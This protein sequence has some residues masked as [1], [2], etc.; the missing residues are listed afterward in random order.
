[1]RQKKLKK[2]FIA[3]AVT[4]VAASGVV[5]PSPTDAANQSFPDVKSSDYFH[6]AVMEL[7]GRGVINGFEDGKFRP[8][9]NVTR[10][11]AAVII[12]GA[13]GL[14]TQNTTNPGFKDVPTTHPYYG[15]ISALANAG[16]IN[17]FADGTFGAEKPITRN[18]MAIIIAK[19]F[20]LEAPTN[21]TLPFTDIYPD[22]KNQIAALYVNG[23]TAGTSNTTFGGTDNVTRGQLAQFVVK[24]E[25]VT[26]SGTVENSTTFTIESVSN[27]TIQTSQGELKIDPSLKTILN[28]SNA[29][30]LEK[31]E[32]KAVVSDGVVKSIA[33][34]TLNSNGSA[35]TPV[36]FDGGKATISGDVKVNA[37]NVAFNNVTVNG[38]LTLT[39]KVAEKFDANG[40]VTNGELVIE[41]APTSPV[42][43]LNGFV[44]AETTGPDVNFSA[45]TIKSI[46]AERDNVKISSDKKLP[47]LK[48]SAKV[49]SIEVNTDVE[50]VTV[51]VTVKIEIKGTG[52]I[53]QFTL[54]QAEELALE[55]AGQIK[56]L[57]VDKN[58][59]AVEIG[60]NV[61]ID[62]LIVP[63]GSNVTTIVKNFNSV[64]G[65]IKSIKDNTG[66]V[67]NPGNNSGGGSGGSSGGGG[68]TPKENFKLSIMHTNDTHG[69]VEMAP[70]RATAVKEVR[71]EN[72]NA[73]L[74]DAGDVFSGTLYFNE[75]QGEADLKLMNY[76][77]YDVMTF[78]NHE[79]D[80]G[81]SAEGHQALV[82]FIEAAKFSFVSSNI[83]FTKD[84]KFTGLFNDL[85]S[86]DPENGKIYSGI[87][88]EIDG[89]K[90]GIFG[91]TTA[92]TENIS[93][94]GSITF[95]DYIEEA[96]KAV[97]AF[98]NM[99]VDKIIAVTHIGFD[100][101]ANVDN[102]QVLAQSVE[103]IDVIVGGHSHTNLG[104]PVVIDE[105][106]A[107]EEKEP[108]VIVQA[109]QYSDYLGTL[110]VTFDKNGEVVEFDGELLTLS[111][112]EEDAGALEILAPYK[113]H[114]DAVQNE[115]I[116]ATA[117]SE[118]E[119]PRT[120]GDNTKPSVRKNETA[121]GNLITDG[122]V[123]KA[124]NYT[125][126][127]VIMAVQNGGGI[128]SAINAGPITVGEVITVLPFGNTL[129][130]MDI[131][132]AELKEAFEHSVSQYPA[133]SGGFL[134]VSTGVKVEFD[135]TKPAGERIISISY[136]NESGQ[137]V[138]IVDSETYTIATNAFTAK[139]GDGFTMFEKAYTE[140][141]VIDLGLSD[142]ENFKEHLESIGT[143]VPTVEG[144]IVDVADAS[145]NLDLAVTKAEEAVKFFERPDYYWSAD[146]E[147]Q[148]KLDAARSAV[149]AVLAIDPEY[150]TSAWNEILDHAK[151]I[152][153]KTVKLEALAEEVNV[154]MRDLDYDDPFG[155]YILTEEDLAKATAEYEEAI[156]KYNDAVAQ[157]ALLYMFDTEAKNRLDYQKR[158]IDQYPIHVENIA[159]AVAAVEGANYTDLAIVE[160][161]EEAKI[162]AVKKAAD[163]AIEETNLYFGDVDTEVSYNA[164]DSNFD[165]KVFNDWGL[166]ETVAISA[167]FKVEEDPE[168]PEQEPITGF[169]N[170]NP[171]NL[172][173][174]QIA[175]YDS[176]SG[177]GGTEILAYDKERELAF[178]TNGA[179]KGFDI[180]SFSDL[181]SGEFKNVSASQDT[182]LL[183]SFD[184]EGVS[185]IT[186][187]ASHPTENLIAISAVSANKTDNGYIVFAT[188]DGE[189][190]NHVEVGAL[191]DMVTFTP[192]GTKAIVANE[193]EPAEDYSVD[194]E[195]SISIININID[196]TSPDTTTLNFTTGDVIT[197]TF[198]GNVNYDDKVRM[199]SHVST[200][201]SV[202]VQLEPEYVTV[203]ADS[204]TAYVSLQENN[205]I[206][207]ID[208]QTN[209]ILSVKGLGVKDYSIAGNEVDAMN[210]K[211]IQLEKQPILSFYMPDAID[212]IMKDGKTYIVTPNEGD[213]RDWDAYSEEIE[214]SDIIENIDLRAEHYEGY[215]QEE[216]DAYVEAGGLEALADGKL[217]LTKEQGK[218]EET[219]KYEALYGFGG[220]SFSIFD[221]ETMELIFDSGSDF[222]KFM[223]EETP[224]YFNTT[225][226]ETKVDNRSDDKG[227]EPET[228]I[229]GE[230]DGK[231][232]S[233]IAL[234]RFGGIAVYDLSDLD[235]PKFV[236]VISSRNFE[237][238]GDLEEDVSPTEVAELAG[239]VSPEGL[240]FI[241]ANES[242]TGK[243]LLV[244]THE[245]SG[246]VAVYELGEGIAIPEEPEEA[247]EVPANEFSG[248]PENPKEYKGSV[249][250]DVS[251]IT[252]LENAV[253]KGDLILSGSLKEDLKF[254]NVTVE[255]NADLSNL[256]GNNFTFEGLVV[257]GD[258]IL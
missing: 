138:E 142:W 191:P 196:Q 160:E 34:L 205:A 134:H 84:S 174:S 98:G 135:S 54:Q 37:D 217:K 140:G 64:K 232:Y 175:R 52:S 68:S 247:V 5:A 67:I 101:N 94:P 139:G 149:N 244:A 250:V 27:A 17:G 248:T 181:K 116:N 63:T 66:S 69:H 240:V 257:I 43:S 33:S 195:G 211:K 22:Y 133:E 184:I 59:T 46:L 154:L 78:G 6:D 56:E 152:I 75:F 143:I 12:A 31:A 73:L 110:D 86:S 161:T 169:Y 126:K 14:D 153:D 128:R 92:E 29:A 227:P 1:M 16:Y 230:I 65:K 71:A 148:N 163:A 39:S 173:A 180:L 238:E 50:K 40:L 127:E 228:A 216:L 202:Y 104:E 159:I 136:T 144:R 60:V 151:E 35:K 178:V 113:E 156:T 36:V 7:A 13:L 246:T 210:D 155:E 213:V 120:G 192:D 199:N 15:A 8:Y 249:K 99:G 157:G 223:A 42:A 89:E 91:L 150:D 203:T 165:V 90:V 171:E 103:G 47:E 20:K 76:M 105:N 125:D 77:G 147:R 30:A 80:L 177:L 26:E 214:V 226:N 168:L 49:S 187:I 222:E 229:V 137:L 131:T 193:G 204:K 102:D 9:N 107:G 72:P 123:N 162:E 132:G 87:V 96:E 179:K 221:A 182:I 25:K 208:L 167:T 79:F 122:M 241:P 146:K 185:D 115:V 100:D 243:A 57:I 3:S 111:E 32:V 119:S 118:L 176:N 225:N 70:K 220:R 28:S 201:D 82:D 19:A 106:I 109:Y 53:D 23:V 233:F 164:D 254:T 117:A 18:H 41:E 218:N 24:A 188:K 170:S 58:D 141:R 212:V 124:K 207:K 215:T 256:E 83:D 234:E 190:I 166:E 235:N 237:A 44:A 121:L 197:L 21:S 85:V 97:K 108:T 48:I 95:E 200:G 242:P 252:N 239:D 112:Y 236:T 251:D 51:N 55:V 93:S 209:Q 255:G 145:N 38:K 61:E 219:G 245:V 258:T 198:D 2:L 114:V 172:E 81:S 186:S 231:P 74:L 253:I 88:K 11:Q 189:Y 130:L 183:E 158:K 224:Q 194:P 129:A 45:S 10:G 4:A 206:A 62:S